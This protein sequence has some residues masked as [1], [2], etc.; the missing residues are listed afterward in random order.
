MFPYFR[1]NDYK[2]KFHKAKET[3]PNIDG[4]QG[5]I[6]PREQA[7]HSYQSLFCRRCY[8]YDCNDHGKSETLYLVKFYLLVLFNR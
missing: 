8:I 5:Q 2:A 3:V 1:Y 7:M 4:D 6:F